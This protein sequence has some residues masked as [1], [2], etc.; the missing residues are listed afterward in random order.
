MQ[1]NNSENKYLGDIKCQRR[2][3]R[4]KGGR[5]EKRGHNAENFKQTVTHWPKV[6]TTFPTIVTRFQTSNSVL[7]VEQSL[8]PMYPLCLRNMSRGAPPNRWLSPRPA[9]TDNIS[10]RQARSPCKEF[11]TSPCPQNP[12]NYKVSQWIATRDRNRDFKPRL[13]NNFHR[14]NNKNW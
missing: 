1:W 11:A 2:L 9:H 6:L 7:K 12:S 4:R 5:G 3:L 13:L 8:I 14:K 10:L